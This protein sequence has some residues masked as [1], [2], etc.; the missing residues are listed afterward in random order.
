MKEK[1][2]FGG[3]VPQSPHYLDFMFYKLTMRTF[4]CVRL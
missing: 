2:L 4:A 1:N 3:Q